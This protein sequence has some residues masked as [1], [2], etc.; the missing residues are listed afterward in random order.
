MSESINDLNTQLEEALK[1]VDENSSAYT[2]LPDTVLANLVGGAYLKGVNA[3]SQ[4]P[5][6]PEICTCPVRCC[7]ASLETYKTI[8]VDDG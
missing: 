3:N 8:P 6:N 4:A 7:D 1:A 2:K 5:D